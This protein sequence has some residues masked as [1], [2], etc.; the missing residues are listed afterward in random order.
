MADKRNRTVTI[1]VVVL[2]A[3]LARSASIFHFDSLNGNAENDRDAYWAI[4]QNLADGNGYCA[5]EGQPTAFRPPLYPCVLAGC[6]LLG[7]TSV[8]AVLH[9][10]LGGLTVLWTTKIA[11]KIGFGTIGCAA[12]GALVAVDPILVRYCANPMTETLFAF[13]VVGLID[14]AIPQDDRSDNDAECLGN[15]VAVSGQHL[16]IK[17]A[18][19]TGV[20]FGLAAMCRPSIW[21]FVLLYPIFLFVWRRRGWIVTPPLKPGQRSVGATEKLAWMFATVVV[22][23]APWTIRNLLQFGRPTVMTTHG[24]YTLALGNNDSFYKNV[25]AEGASEIWP[26]GELDAWQQSLESEM[27]EQGIARVDENA[28]DAFHQRTAIDWIRANP[29]MFLESSWVRLVRFWAIKPN[30]PDSHGSINLLVGVFYVIQF[31]F[32]GIGLIRSE[33]PQRFPVIL[34]IIVSLA[35]LH[36]FYW[37]NARMR[38][39]IQPYLSILAIAC[40]LPR[41][42]YTK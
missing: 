16:E 37:S 6:I 39:P 21:V 42:S 35:L 22:V 34:A 7:G 1:L 13:L 14:S 25:V 40:F 15:E 4:A 32:V 30:S 5:N 11:Q 26:R 12:A 31:L 33:L 2:V 24:G 3:G 19:K 17:K 9:V 41:Q 18:I 38:G 10:V 8:V 23:V 36:S 20:W 29:V 27:D 28:R